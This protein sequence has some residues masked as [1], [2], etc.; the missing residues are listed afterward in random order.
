[1][2]RFRS[3]SQFFLRNPITTPM[4]WGLYVFIYFYLVGVLGLLIIDSAAF[5]ASYIWKPL[6][7]AGLGV[8]YFSVWWE[9]KFEAGLAYSLKSLL[10][11]ALPFTIPGIY[12]WRKIAAF[13]LRRRYNKEINEIRAAQAKKGLSH[14][15]N[16]KK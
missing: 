8:D 3:R 4:K 2:P 1:M 7:S 16:K 9:Y 14:K 12:Y 11:F 15:F 13:L 10:V 6:N 5:D